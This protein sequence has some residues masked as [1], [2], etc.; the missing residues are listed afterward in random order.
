[1][2]FIDENGALA[3]KRIDRIL[4][5]NGREVVVDYK[6]GAPDPDRVARDRE[7]VTRYCAAIER[8]TGRE[9]AGLVW[10][11]DADTDVLMTCQNRNRQCL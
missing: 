6:G 2:R 1:M 4:R 3:E 8:I 7:Q 9:C 11:I 10:Y 5:E